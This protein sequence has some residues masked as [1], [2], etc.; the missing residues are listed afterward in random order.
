MLRAKKSKYCENTAGMT[1]RNS[2]KEIEK[3]FELR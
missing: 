3:P 1:Y 2:T